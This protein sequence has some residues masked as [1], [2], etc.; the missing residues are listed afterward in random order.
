MHDQRDAIFGGELVELLHHD[1]FEF[2][3]SRLVGGVDQMTVSPAEHP[4]V[5]SFSAVVAGVALLIGEFFLAALAAGPGFLGIECQA[6]R[7]LLKPR[8]DVRDLPR[9]LCL[10]R[11]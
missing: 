6:M 9:R 11:Q 1:G 3:G 5:E 8:A 7:N 4:A 10:E 2:F